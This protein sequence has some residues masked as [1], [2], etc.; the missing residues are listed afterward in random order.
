MDN[1]GD[2]LIIFNQ[3]KLSICCSWSNDIVSDHNEDLQLDQLLSHMSPCTV[4]MLYGG[5]GD[6]FVRMSH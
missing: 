4:I 2:Q 3:L 6:C 1:E 5:A